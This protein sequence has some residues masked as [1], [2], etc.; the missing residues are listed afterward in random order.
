MDYGGV[1]SGGA[2]KPLI[3]AAVKAGKAALHVAAEDGEGEDTM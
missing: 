3:Y 1:E 2:D